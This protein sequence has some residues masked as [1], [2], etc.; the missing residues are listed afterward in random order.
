MLL[1]RSLVKKQELSAVNPFVWFA[2][3][4]PNNQFI[5]AFKLAELSSVSVRS[6]EEIICKQQCDIVERYVN[7]MHL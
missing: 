7:Y 2:L 6:L 4:R 5:R 1:Y 3:A